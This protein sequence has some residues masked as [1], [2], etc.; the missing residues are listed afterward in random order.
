MASRHVTPVGIYSK[1]PAVSVTPNMQSGNNPKL[2]GV[3]EPAASNILSAKTEIDSRN[4]SLHHKAST[5]NIEL[6]VL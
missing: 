2:F 1:T 3:R 4:K 6:N 5:S